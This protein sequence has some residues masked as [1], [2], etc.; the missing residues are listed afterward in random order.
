MAIVSK[1]KERKNYIDA[2]KDAIRGSGGV[3]QSM[4]PLG[5]G[6]KKTHHNIDVLA[7]VAFRVRLDDLLDRGPR[8]HLL[9]GSH[10]NR[11]W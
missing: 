11:G 10:L 8:V 9:A 5:R 1:Q 2:F 7:H 3:F 6:S 4:P